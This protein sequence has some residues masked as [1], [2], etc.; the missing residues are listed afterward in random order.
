MTPLGLEYSIEARRDSRESEALGGFLTP[1]CLPRLRTDLTHYRRAPLCICST[2]AQDV[3]VGTVLMFALL[4]CVCVCVCVC[5]SYTHLFICTHVHTTTLAWGMN[6]HVRARDK[7][8]CA[9]RS[10]KASQGQ[11]L[12]AAGGAEAGGPPM[13]GIGCIFMFMYV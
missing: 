7:S 4:L 3:A 11:M 1:L 12:S 13:A 9:C 2:V 5:V 6:S 8:V 10:P